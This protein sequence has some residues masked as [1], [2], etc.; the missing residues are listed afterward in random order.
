VILTLAFRS[1]VV[2]GRE[3]RETRERREEVERLRL[4]GRL[5]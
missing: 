4:T 2:E 1:Q 3:E 5:S